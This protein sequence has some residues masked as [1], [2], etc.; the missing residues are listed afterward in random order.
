MSKPKFPAKPDLSGFLTEFL[1][2]KPDMSGPALSSSAAK[3]LPDLSGTC[4]GFQKM[5]PEMSGPLFKHIWPF[6]L[7]SG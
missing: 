1:K 2:P 3:S 4:S 5:E 7:I 6:S